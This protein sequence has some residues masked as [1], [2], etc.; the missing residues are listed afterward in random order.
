MSTFA[1]TSTAADPSPEQVIAMLHRH[2]RPTRIR[3]SPAVRPSHAIA[4]DEGDDR[5]VICAFDDR[6]A[7]IDALSKHP[8]PRLLLDGQVSA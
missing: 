6:S 4:V 3:F 2:L 1:V 5:I 8:D 7:I